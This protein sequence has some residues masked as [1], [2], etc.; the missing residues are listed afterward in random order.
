[1]LVLNSNY[2]GFQA[3]VKIYLLLTKLEFLSLELERQSD[4]LRFQRGKYTAQSVIL[5]ILNIQI[6]IILTLK[7]FLVKGTNIL[8][9]TKTQ[10]K[11]ILS[12]CICIGD[13]TFTVDLQLYTGF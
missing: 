8:L 3:K 9:F 6:L 13:H 7:L 2:I 11:T 1:M 5:S 12:R 10:D 4:R